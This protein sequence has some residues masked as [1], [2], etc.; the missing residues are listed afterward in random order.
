MKQLPAPLEK[1]LAACAKRSGKAPD[2]YLSHLLLVDYKKL[3]GKH[4]LL[5][6]NQ[7]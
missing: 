1:L 3:Y 2:E 5:D 4:Y 6:N 7:R